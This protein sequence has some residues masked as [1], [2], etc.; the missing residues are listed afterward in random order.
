MI[1]TR[2][3]FVWYDQKSRQ[4]SIINQ[5]STQSTNLLL[6]AKR[7]TACGCFI[8]QPSEGHRQAQR[9]NKI[10]LWFSN[11]LR[12]P[13]FFHL[14][15]GQLLYLHYADPRKFRP[16]Y[17]SRYLVVHPP[18]LLYLIYT[19]IRLNYFIKLLY[20][21]LTAAFKTSLMPSEESGLQP[22]VITTIPNFSFG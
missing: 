1:G 7:C 18:T 10:T 12:F 2:Q 15:P 3:Y 17:R 9:G 8:T 14:F 20:S 13:A 22:F 6:R 21:M 16:L 19:L 4:H 11:T 5:K